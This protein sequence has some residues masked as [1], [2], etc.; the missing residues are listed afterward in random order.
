MKLTF[1]VRFHTHPGQSLFVSADH[2]LLGGGILDRAVPLHCVDSETWQVSLE[3]PDDSLNEPIP[4]QYLLRQSN[5]TFEMDVAQGRAINPDWRKLAAVTTVDSWNSPGFVENVFHTEPF[6]RVLLHDNRTTIS[7]ATP[8]QHVTHR[9]RVRAPVLGPGQALCLLGSSSRFRNWNTGQPLLLSREPGSDILSVELDL[10]G[11]VL[12][13]EYKYG[14]FDQGSNQFMRFEAGENRKLREAA[15]ES[16]GLVV[17][18]DGFARLPLKFWRGAGVAMPVFSL[19]SEKSFGIGEFL[20][21]KP[22]ADWSKLVGLKVIQILPVNDTTTTHTWMDSYPYAAIS[23]FALH[24]IYLNLEKIGGDENKPLLKKLEPERLRLN[25]LEAVDYEAVLKAKLDFIKQIFPSQRRDT[26]ARADF[27][28]FFRQNK[29]WLVPYSAFCHLR[30]K[31]GT[32]DFSLWSE[33]SKYDANAIAK[34]A[35]QGSPA[36][37][38]ISLNH[39]VQFH[40]HLQLKEAAEYLHEQGVILKGDIPIG[41]SRHGA[42]AWQEPELFHMDMQAGA[43]PDAFAAKG[44]NWGFPTYS[45]PRMK[46]NGFAWWR[47]RFEQM[48]CYFD[49]FR[50]DHILGFFR[51]WSIPEHAVEGILGYFVPAIPVELEEFSNR[52]VL[53][54][55]Q[56]FLKPYIT[57]EVLEEIF[58]A[59]REEVKRAFLKPEKGGGYSLKTEFSTQRQIE[60][61]FAGLKPGKRNEKLKNGLFDL[62]SNVILFEAGGSNGRK[63]HFRLGMEDTPSFRHLPV[64]VQSR[65]KELYVDYFFRRQDVMW[66]EEALEKLLA[67][68]RATNM[69]ICGEDLGMVPDCVPDTMRQLGLLS[70]EIQRMPKRLGQ[71][72]SRPADAPYLS[73]VTPSTHDMSTI[74]GWWEE[75]AKFSQK[76]YNLELGQPGVAPRTCEARICQAIIQQHLESPAMWSIFMLQDLLG[77]DEDLRRP[78]VQSERINVPAVNGY[79][80][81]YRMHL[82][83]EKLQAAETFNQRLKALVQDSGR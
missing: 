30:D 43:P 39:F 77:M 34:L 71:E 68:K 65:L 54:D 59:D 22:L 60:K 46:Q 74:R 20:D 27:Q 26:F 7:P 10:S 82:T 78:D 32:A 24:P 72:F 16:G 42:D 5:G 73:V 41:V 18:D 81:R 62:V 1:K 64:L 57:D 14:V 36:Y 37:D 2:P 50:I 19:R 75:D 56:R 69:L 58:A 35:G 63:F 17:T 51:I 12:P 9:F 6:Q 28:E 80:W 31:L 40:L 70:L 15:A 47:R 13:V 21:L 61:Y 25:A 45:W 52:G 3:L 23:A 79:Y 44:Q 4:Y 38:S 8:D 67:L 66:K 55:P 53:F 83:L 48:G 11:G 29:H 33:H 49:A 76:F